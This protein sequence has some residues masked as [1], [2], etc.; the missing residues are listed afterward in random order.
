VEPLAGV[1]TDDALQCV[2]HRL[3]EEPPQALQA[4]VE[5]VLIRSAFEHCHH[6]QVHTAA[7]LGITRNVLRTQLKRLGLLALPRAA[8]SPP[9]ATATSTS[10]HA[11]LR[12]VA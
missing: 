2:F 6:N 9:S 5:G 7:L 8:L 4:R 1:S 10:S 12:A 3:F 11:S